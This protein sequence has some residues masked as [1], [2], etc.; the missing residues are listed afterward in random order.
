MK[1][2]EQ[3][4]QQQIADH[5]GCKRCYYFEVELRGH[6]VGILQYGANGRLSLIELDVARTTI[7]TTSFVY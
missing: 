4:T 1:S 3:H 6:V 5:N 7:V 2:V